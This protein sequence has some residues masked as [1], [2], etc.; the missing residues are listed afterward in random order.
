M[1]DN[2]EEGPRHKGESA[3]G[4]PGVFMFDGWLLIVLI[5]FSCEEGR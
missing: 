1:G 3:P 2:G 5:A 4:C